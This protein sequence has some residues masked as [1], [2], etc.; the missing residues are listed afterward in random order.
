MAENTTRT[1]YGAY[2]QA[3]KHLGIPFT[4]KANTTLNE[5]FNIQANVL[6]DAGM[7]PNLGYFGMGNG[8]HTI[9]AGADNSPVIVPK[10]FKSTS[11]ALY[12]QMPFIL[13][14]IGNDLSAA[15]RVKYALRRLEQRNGVTY[16]A[17]YLKRLDLSNVVANMFLTSVVNGVSNTTPYVPDS[18]VLHPTPPLLTIPSVQ[19]ADGTYV[20]ASAPLGIVLDENDVSEWLNVCKIING[21]TNAAMVTE[22]AICSGI[23][24]QVQYTDPGGQPFQMLEAIAVQVCDFMNV[25]APLQ[26]NSSGTTFNLDIGATEPL[27]RSQA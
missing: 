22:V 13:R 27:Y 26:F 21:N 8:G 7:Y 17:Y 4:L 10:V 6:P 2:L 12:N 1:V 5:L 20:S 15:E 16:I 9:E 23:N 11:A 3:C 25:G 19:T 14:P 24:K 18:S